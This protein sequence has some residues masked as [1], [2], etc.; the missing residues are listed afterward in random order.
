MV[1]VRKSQNLVKNRKHNILSF[2][3]KTGPWLALFS[4]Y[5]QIVLLNENPNLVNDLFFSSPVANI[6]STSVSVSVATSVT[7]SVTA[8]FI[9]AMT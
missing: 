8:T 5:F 6:I 2:N 9:L 4:T 7:K 1:H 3:K